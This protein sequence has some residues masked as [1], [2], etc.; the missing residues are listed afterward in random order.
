MPASQN[1][2][3][4]PIEAWKLSHV[5]A[6]PEMAIYCASGRLLLRAATPSPLVAD[7]V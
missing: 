6:A 3:S 5:D 1:A 2:A 4:N 7:A